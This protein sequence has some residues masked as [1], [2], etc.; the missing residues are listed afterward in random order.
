MRLV[1]FVICLNALFLLNGCATAPGRPYLVHG[2]EKSSAVKIE[3]RRPASE[4]EKKVFTYLITSEAYGIHRFAESTAA[5]VGVRL[6]AHRAYEAIPALKQ[7]PVIKVNHFVVYANLQSE[8]RQGALGAAIGGAIGAVIATQG[9]SAKVKVRTTKIDSY[10]FEETKYIEFRRGYYIEHENPSN[11]PV[12]IVYIETE[13]LGRRI[14]TRSIA[15]SLWSEPGITLTEI[16]D[17]CILNHLSLY[18][19]IKGV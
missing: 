12:N 13:I 5:P 18:K 8:L 17:V 11:A 14:A 6:L 15:P 7:N 4:R 2:L 1:F 3:D 9:S 16:I 10:L 19:R